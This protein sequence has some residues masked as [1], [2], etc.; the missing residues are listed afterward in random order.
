LKGKLITL[1]TIGQQGGNI[2][3]LTLREGH[4]KSTN[5]LKPNDSVSQD[6]QL[7]NSIAINIGGNS[8]SKNSDSDKSKYTPGNEQPQQEG[9]QPE[10]LYIERRYCTA[11]NI[12]QPLR[13][14]HCKECHK[15]TAQYDHHCP[16]IGIIL[17]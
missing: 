9:D 12:D 16:W 8:E 1:E 5:F 3:F 4:A 7:V 15:C 11:C 2:E 13:S 6:I 14:K 17:S 10:T